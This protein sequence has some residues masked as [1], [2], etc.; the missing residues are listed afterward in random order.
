[1]KLCKDCKYYG[2]HTQVCF[3]K[4]AVSEKDIIS[5]NDTLYR[6]SWMRNSFIRK[7]NKKPNTN[8]YCKGEAILFEPER[9]WWQFKTK[10]IK[11]DKP[12]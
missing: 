10:T 11:L 5:G 3:H 7:G 8:G 4:K 12:K 9:K 2:K 1:M 6:C